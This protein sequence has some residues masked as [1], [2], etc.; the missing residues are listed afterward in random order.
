MDPAFADVDS[1]TSVNGSACTLVEFWL[2]I[3]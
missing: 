3:M 2:W 1:K